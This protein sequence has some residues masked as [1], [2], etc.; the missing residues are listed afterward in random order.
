MIIKSIVY[1]IVSYTNNKKYFDY[2]FIPICFIFVLFAFI[3]VVWHK[4]I[5]V[6]FNKVRIFMKKNKKDKV[7]EGIELEL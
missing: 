6:Y 7:K 1:G 2:H 4:A 3:E 5:N